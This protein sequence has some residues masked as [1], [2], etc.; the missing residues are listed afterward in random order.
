MDRGEII[1]LNTTISECLLDSLNIHKN[2]KNIH[3]KLV[4][5]IIAVPCLNRKA[6]LLILIP[7]LK[8][9]QE[10]ADFVIIDPGEKS[11]MIT[12]T[13]KTVP[14]IPVRSTV[15]SA[16]EQAIGSQNSL[17]ELSLPPAARGY[18]CPTCI[19]IWDRNQL[20]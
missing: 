10:F 15:W 19:D 14:T 2:I 20:F 12:S 11:R 4:L 1:K 5:Y 17:I 8:S 7:G 13:T 3:W 18:F 6:F 9:T 16:Y